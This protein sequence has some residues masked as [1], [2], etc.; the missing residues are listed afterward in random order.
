VFFVVS[1]F[2]ITKT[3]AQGRGGLFKPD[4][5]DF[6]VRRIGRILPLLGLSIAAGIG[7]IFF[8]PASAPHLSY[9]LGG[10]Q[11]RYEPLFW[12]SIPFFS[13][14]WFRAFISRHDYGLHWD[15][16]WSLSVE[17]QF[18]LFYPYCLR[19]I[20]S[21]NG[22]YLF[23]GSWVLLG[24]AVRLGGVLFFPDEK[25]W[26]LGS[27]ANF[28]DIAMG[29]LLYLVR[30]RHGKELGR[31]KWLCRFLCLSGLFMLLGAYGATPTDLDY[32]RR[33]F[34]NTLV[35]G[36]VFLLLLGGLQ[37]DGFK[38]GFWAPLRW[39]GKL[40]YGAYLLHPLVLFF[41]WPVLSGF[42]WLPA[43]LLFSGAVSGIAWVSYRSFE[44]PIN[45]WVRSRF[46]GAARD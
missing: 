45:H 27:F 19:K 4:I 44:V 37:L 3:I 16:L 12:V 8:I 5:R 39:P 17:E 2:L 30:E 6:Y 40:S 38:S 7:A 36:G 21:K 28:D 43:F 22:L 11:S 13:F 25:Y 46:K 41:L 10:Q 9:C 20:G 24:L 1:G 31:E 33:I 29:C 15:V 34:G 32:G 26:N 14:N 42:S 18:Y 35:G 23:L